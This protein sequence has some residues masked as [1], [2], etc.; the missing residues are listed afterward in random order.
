VNALFS[1][2]G[3]VALVTGGTSGIG[4]M[5]A[6][7]LVENG[8]RTYIVGRSADTCATVAK[9]F[10]TLGECL[11]LPGDLSTMAGVDA[12]I[13]ALSAKEKVLDILVN[14][15]GAMYDAP[16]DEFTEEGWDSIVDL[17]LKS[18]FFLS[19]K[20]LPLLRAAVKINELA[21]VINIGS[22][23]G[24]RVG[25][26]ENYSYQAAKAGLHHLT[27]SLAKRLGP[28]NIVVNAIAPGFFESRLTSSRDMSPAVLQ[29][30]PR[31][32]MGNA[33]DIVAAVL[34]LGSRA[35]SFVAGAVI[36]VSGGMTL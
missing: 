35:G 16:L 11:P 7:G 28:E 30:V 32:R 31:R 29:M 8:A 5:I 26:K 33:D 15:A 6:K 18:V 23:G 10:S 21:S 25:P 22:V 13:A 4:H 24:Q 34:Y 17:N 3:K 14:N 2:K 36:P 9:E 19:Q 12:V 27:G 20:A 1:V